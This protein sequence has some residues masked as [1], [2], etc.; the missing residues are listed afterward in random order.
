MTAFLEPVREAR[1]DQRGPLEIAAHDKARRLH[2]A[3]ARVLIAEEPHDR[4]GD[5]RQR[6]QVVDQRVM[7]FGIERVELVQRD[8]DPVAQGDVALLGGEGGGVARGEL[9]G[10]PLGGI[11]AG[12]RQP[13]IGAPAEDEDRLGAH[14]SSLSDCSEAKAPPRRCR[15]ASARNR[16]RAGP[17]RGAFGAV[18]RA[19]LA[20]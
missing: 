11:G 15:A 10:V 3:R 2:V 18:M 7:A 1:Q 4:D 5:A 9:D 12:E 19:S 14:S 17:R 8:A 20:R 13:D 16:P 6:G